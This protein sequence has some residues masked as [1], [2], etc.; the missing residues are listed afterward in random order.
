MVVCRNRVELEPWRNRHAG[1]VAY[2]MVAEY[3]A[4]SEWVYGGRFSDVCAEQRETIE[5]SRVFC[6]R[7]DSQNNYC[8]CS[9]SIYTVSLY[10]AILTF[11]MYIG[12]NFQNVNLVQIAP[13]IRSC[14]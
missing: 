7:I 8:A 1:A 10:L 2:E 3:G 5:R 6:L 4:S 11:Y 12:E 13:L 9:L 14:S